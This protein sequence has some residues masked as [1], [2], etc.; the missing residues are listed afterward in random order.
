MGRFEMGVICRRVGAR[1]RDEETSAAFWRARAARLKRLTARGG[2]TGA[3]SG[4]REGDED[5]D[6]FS[7]RSTTSGDADVARA[8]W[9]L[10]A[11]TAATTTT[12]GTA[13]PSTWTPRAC[14]T[15]MVTST[16]ASGSR[17][18]ASRGRRRGDA[19]ALDDA[20]DDAQSL[21]ALRAGYKTLLREVTA[22]HAREIEAMEQK[23]ASL[24]DRV[25]A[26][27]TAAESRD[28]GA[29]R[30]RSPRREILAPRSP[31]DDAMGYELSPMSAADRTP[32]PMP[33]E[34]SPEAASAGADEKENEDA[35]STPKAF[36]P[37][38]PPSRQGSD[39]DD[40]WIE[41]WERAEFSRGALP[42]NVRPG[43]GF[44]CPFTGAVV[45]RTP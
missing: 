18:L 1:M 28:G 29:A 43:K 34:M 14:P 16:S 7:T 25:R 41:A 32:P 37:P 24:R 20:L 4:A 26:L 6:A 22:R 21:D 36:R 19:D 45:N 42:L 10:T 3:E 15:T 30:R 13:R 12:T 9:A 11:T 38:R 5:D 23:M 39:A 31:G 27:E 35:A 2:S 17:W 8:S 40:S 44:V 33:R